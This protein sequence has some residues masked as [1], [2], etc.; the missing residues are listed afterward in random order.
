MALGQFNDVRKRDLIDD[1]N[2]DFV[3]NMMKRDGIAAGEH[4]GF[5]TRDMGNGV[6]Q[7]SPLFE[8]D[9][10]DGKYHMTAFL[11]KRSGTFVHHMHRAEESNLT[12]R[13][14]KFHRRQISYDD[15]RWY[16]SINSIP[17]PFENYKA[18]ILIVRY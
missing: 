3:S 4:V 6:E 2:Y 12:A 13:Y 16:V 10:I 14:D 15:V 17:L 11:D 8:V 1:A 7:R 9:G 5:Q 18:G